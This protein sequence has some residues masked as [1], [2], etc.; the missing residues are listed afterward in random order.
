MKTYHLKTSQLLGICKSD[1]EKI[2]KISQLFS[3]CAAM[4]EISGSSEDFLNLLQDVRE[5]ALEDDDLSFAAGGIKSVT[6]PKQ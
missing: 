4:D 3:V 2:E 6:P 5:D 1:S